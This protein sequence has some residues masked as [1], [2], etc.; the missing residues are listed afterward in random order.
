MG[1]EVHATIA[2][3]VARVAVA[4][5]LVGERHARLRLLVT[6]EQ[7]GEGQSRNFEGG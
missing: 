1:S 4:L 2:E 3:W 6:G 5:D 7:L